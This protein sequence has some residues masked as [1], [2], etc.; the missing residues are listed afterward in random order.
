MT[1]LT[2]KQLKDIAKSLDIKFPYKIK[3]DK[4]LELINEHTEGKKYIEKEEIKIKKTISN[5]QKRET[6][7]EKRQ[8]KKDLKKDL[9][10]QEKLDLSEYATPLADINELS[11]AINLLVEYGKPI[12][13]DLKKSYEEKKISFL[14]LVKNI[15]SD[16]SKD[17]I[18][19]FEIKDNQGI[20]I[21]KEIK[22]KLESCVPSIS[23]DIINTIAWSNTP[24]K[25]LSAT[26]ESNHN[27]NPSDIVIKFNTNINISN[28]GLE[29]IN[30]LGVSLKASFTS[31]DIGFYNG[32][33]CKFVNGIFPLNMNVLMGSELEISCKCNSKNYGVDIQN[34]INCERISY[35]DNFYRT[36]L[37]G[38][39]NI[40]SA[41]EIKSLVKK[42]LSELK[43]SNKE[44]Y[45]NIEIERAKLLN[46]SREK[47]YDL[48]KNIPGSIHNENQIK[49]SVPR[50]LAKKVIANSL[51]IIESQIDLPSNYIKVSALGSSVKIEGGNLID[52]YITDEGDNIDLIYSKT[53]GGTINLSCGGSKSINFR[54]KFASTI[55]SSFKIDGSNS[56]SSLKYGDLSGGGG[57]EMDSMNTDEEEESSLIDTDEEESSPMDTDEEEETSLMDT[58]EEIINPSLEAIILE[59]I[60]VY[61]INKTDYIKELNNILENDKN[62]KKIITDYKEILD[63]SGARYVRKEIRIGRDIDNIKKYIESIIDNI[64]YKKNLRNLNSEFLEVFDD[65]DSNCMPTTCSLSG[66][67]KKTKK[68]SSRKTKKKKKKKKKTKRLK[69]HQ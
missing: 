44:I 47:Y 19:A 53:G 12:D 38:D 40:I 68:R 26:N 51:R 48:L 65:I 13:E 66:G 55:P 59:A 50:N 52:Q 43:S 22:N 14:G 37:D 17:L 58:D 29:N 35:Q 21:A 64:S 18:K 45:K 39:M 27:D 8:N 10:K 63:E 25:F 56:T 1:K 32:S 2:I 23:K 33:I 16:L 69:R 46:G 5:K 42:K 24:E 30:W 34:M 61:M 60:D 67:K 31:G 4:I 36:Y 41:K 3:K 20:M 62:L 57:D 9:K 49:I 7:K 11:T 28:Y 15:S 54:I 6:K